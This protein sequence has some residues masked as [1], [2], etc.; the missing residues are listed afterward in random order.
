M[1]NRLQIASDFAKKIMNEHI[2][3]V[4]LFGSV[5]RGEDNEYSDIDILIIA[6]DMMTVE[7]DIGEVVMDIILEKKE[8][9]SAHIIS[10]DHYNKT[11]NF[12]FIE[13]VYDDGIILESN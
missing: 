8:H 1:N 9:I 10:E 7:D 13:K 12:S 4:V 2:K 5:A 3:E 11:K 6:D